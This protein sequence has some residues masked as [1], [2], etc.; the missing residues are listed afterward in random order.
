M[1]FISQCGQRYVNKLWAINENLMYVC[2]Y[3]CKIMAFISQ[4]GQR[5]VHKCWAINDNSMYVRT[6][7]HK[8]TKLVRLWHLSHNVVRDT[9]TKM[10]DCRGLIIWRDCNNCSPQY[11]NWTIT[12][13]CIISTCGT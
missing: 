11:T 9:Y 13:Q 12:N 10:L 2:I 7:I 8:I 5:Y 3:L 6:Y 4:C 1:A